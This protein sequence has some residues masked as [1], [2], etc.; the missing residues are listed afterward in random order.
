MN[1]F[2][3]FSDNSRVWIYPSTKELNNLESE[4]L[5]KELIP[6]TKSWDSHGTPLKAAVEIIENQFVVFAIDESI[7]SPSG[8]A[9]DR[10]VKK[11]KEL[12]LLLKIDFFNRLKMVILKDNVKKTIAF[13]DL[14]E[15]RDWKI[16]NPLVKSVSE[17]NHSFLI[18]VIESGLLR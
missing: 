10:S 8:C 7:E 1:Y 17:L 9:I 12:G 6:F 5:L 15:Y 3:E 14:E 11:M 13:A 16:Y 18:P 2:S 4:I